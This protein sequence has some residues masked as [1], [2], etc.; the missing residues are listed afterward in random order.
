MGGDGLSRRLMLRNANSGGY[1][2]GFVENDSGHGTTI[3]T[4]DSLGYIYVSAFHTNTG[5]SILLEFKKPI[6]VNV[7]DEVSIVFTLTSGRPPGSFCDY[8]I[9]SVVFLGGTSIRNVMGNT[10]SKTISSSENLDK[11]SITNNSTDNT[12]TFTFRIDVY[13]NG[14]KMI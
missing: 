4:V 1:A 14:N 13:L 11:I 9:G 7:G 2:N 6:P 12:Y 10:Y 8:R 5:N 3:Y